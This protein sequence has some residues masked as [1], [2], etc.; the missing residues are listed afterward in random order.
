MRLPNTVIKRFLLVTL[1]ALVLSSGSAL[2][3]TT[4]YVDDDNCPGPGTGTELDPYCKIQDGICFLKDGGGGTVRVKPGYYNESLRMFAGISVI[5]TDGPTVTTL[6]ADGKPCVTSDCLDSTN[7]LTCSTV[8]YGTG[9]TPADRLE[10][11]RITGGAGYYRDFGVGIPPNA[12]VGGAI[13]VFNSSP[14]ITNNEIVDNALSHPNETLHYW[15]GG[16][17]VGGGS[18]GA[19]TQPV[20]TYNLIQENAADPPAGQNKNQVTYGLGGGIYVGA[21]TAPTVSYNTISSNQAGDTN[22]LDQLAGGGGMIVYSL[23]PSIVPQISK[24][25]IQDNSGADFGGGVSFAQGYSLTGYY[26]TFGVMENNIVQLNRS[27]TG[28]GIHTSTTKALIR[29]NTIV[30]NT[31]EFGGGVTHGES[32]LPDGQAT[33]VNNIIAF[34]T[35]LLYGAGG[36]GIY[37][38][39]PD[40]RYNDLYENVPNNVDG[41]FGDDHLIG[42]FG[43]VSVDP[44]FLSRIPGNRDLH[45]HPSSPVIDIGDDSEI[46]TT[47]LDGNPRMQDGDLDGS[48]RVDMGAYEFTPD[49]RQRRSAR[50]PRRRRRRDGVPDVCRL[51]PYDS[52]RLRASATGG[53]QRCASIWASAACA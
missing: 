47:D 35:S 17:Y 26:P 38:S 25:L 10:G 11:F 8:V 12:L 23:S 42:V 4:V 14:T 39:L 51:R 53:Q 49:T 40:V 6:D 46:P 52:R 28:G 15:G 27:F 18:Y 33:L 3:Q 20:I 22:K 30:D 21:Y 41:D 43:N 7:N 1:L 24:N 48:S 9:P 16:I 32:M 13:F 19:P 2:A 50:L 44:M 5:S 36:L 31:A 34:N 29:N 37:Y 45:L